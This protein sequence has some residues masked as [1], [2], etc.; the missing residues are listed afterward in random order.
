MQTT[1]LLGR[2]SRPGALD[3]MADKLLYLRIH[4]LV[5]GK[6]HQG[7]K[8]TAIK[9]YRDS[10][11]KKH[12]KQSIAVFSVRPDGECV[13]RR[14]D[15]ERVPLPWPKPG[16][17][18]P[19]DGFTQLI[20]LL[21]K[22]E[23]NV[24]TGDVE[25]NTIDD[26]DY[27]YKWQKIPDDE[28]LPGFGESDSEEQYDTQTLRDLEADVNTPSSN[29]KPKVKPPL[30]AEEAREAM[31]ECMAVMIKKWKDKRLPLLKT[32]A[33][34]LWRI[35]K[36][37][38]CRK[39]EIAKHEK[40]LDEVATRLQNM[41]EEFNRNTWW[42]LAEIKTTCL[43]MQLSL[44]EREEATWLRELMRRKN[45]PKRPEE[46]QHARKEKAVVEETER[47]EESE[48]DDG[49]DDDDETIGSESSEEFSSEDEGL[50]G[51]IVSDD[52]RDVVNGVEVEIEGEDEVEEEL[53][54]QHEEAN[55]LDSEESDSNSSEPIIARRR[56]PRNGKRVAQVVPLSDEEEEYFHDAPE[57]VNSDDMDDGPVRRSGNNKGKQGVV[58]SSDVEM[59]DVE[60]RVSP[61]TVVKAEPSNQFPKATPRKTS[62]R[63]IPVIDLTMDESPDSKKSR[64]SKN[65]VSEDSNSTFV[66]Q[67]TK[68]TRDSPNGGSGP[69][70]LISLSGSE[71]GVNAEF[72]NA[73]EL[74]EKHWG[75][76][77]DEMKG[78]IKFRFE[79]MRPLG[80]VGDL[81]YMVKSIMKQLHL[82]KSKSIPGLDD[83][84]DKIY[85]DLSKLYICWTLRKV[86]DFFRPLDSNTLEF[87]GIDHRFKAFCDALG[88][89]V[90]EF[91]EEEGTV[92]AQELARIKRKGRRQSGRQEAYAEELDES[93]DFMPT[94][95]GSQKRKRRLVQ[96]D[97]TAREKRDRALKRHRNLF[98]RIR[99]QLMNE[100]A[101]NGEIAINVGHYARHKDINFNPQLR[102]A[103]KQHQVN[104]VRFI[105]GQLVAQ[106]EGEGAGAL[107]AHTMGLGKTFQVI[108]FLYTLATAAGS[109]DPAVY[110][111]IPKELRKSR[112]LILSPP[113]LVDNWEDEFHKWIPSIENTTEMDLSNL[114]KIRRADSTKEFEFR[115]EN[116]KLWY[117]EGGVLLI[118]YATFRNFIENPLRKVKINGEVEVRP[119][120]PEKQYQE[121]KRMLH[122]GPNIIVAD[123][124][125]TLKNDSNKITR[126]AKGFKSKARIAI[127][128]SPLMNNLMEYY[129]MID[130]IDPG[131]LGSK[132]EFRSKYEIPIS[133]GVYADSDM[134]SRRYSLKMLRV[135]AKNLEPKVHRA[136]IQDIVE[137]KDVLPGKTEFMVCVP[138]TPLQKEMYLEYI[139]DPTTTG[140]AEQSLTP[141]YLLG[142]V[143]MLKL[144]ASH[145]QCFVAR[146]EN[147]EAEAQA[148]TQKFRALYNLPAAKDPIGNDNDASDI[149]A[150]E[151]PY[152]SVEPLSEEL[153][154][155]VQR[156]YPWA[157]EIFNAAGNGEAM[158]HSVKIMALKLIIE[159]SI[160]AGDQVLVFSHYIDTLNV[161]ERF[162]KEWGVEYRRLDGKTK[163]ST[164][165][166]STKEFNSGGGQ[167]YLVATEA[168]GLG[169][170]LPGA[171]RVVIFDFGWTPMSEEQAIGRSYRIGQMKHV[172][173]YR[174]YLGGT[175]EEII[176][177]KVLYKNQLQSRVVDQKDPVRKSTKIL[178]E[179]LKPPTEPPQEDLTPYMGKD[180]QVLDKIIERVD[181][182]RSIL[183]TETFESDPDDILT[184]DE[185]R[186]AELIYEE[187]MGRRR[188]KLDDYARKS[189]AKYRRKTEGWVGGVPSAAASFSAV[190]GPAG[191]SAGALPVL[192]ARTSGPP[193]ASSKAP[194]GAPIPPPGPART[195][196]PMGFPALPSAPIPAPPVISA[197]PPASFSLP[198]A[199]PATPSTLP[200]VAPIPAPPGIP[201]A[202]TPASPAL[203]TARPG[204]PRQPPTATAALPRTLPASPVPHAASPKPRVSPGSQITSGAS[205]RPPSVARASAGS[206]ALGSNRTASPTPLRT[207]LTSVAQADAPIG[208]LV[209]TTPNPPRESSKAPTTPAV[210]TTE[211]SGTLPVSTP[212]QG[213]R[214]G[215]PRGLRTSPRS[216]TP[217]QLQNGELNMGLEMDGTNDEVDRHLDLLNIA[218]SEVKNKFGLKN[219]NLPSVFG[220]GK[221]DE[222][223]K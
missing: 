140:G 127:T 71:A 182:I 41:V 136:G 209:R 129:A 87:L 70:K 179:Y 34:R 99:K 65:T 35:A 81:F 212:S 131:Y 32:R 86:P 180:L 26:W 30:S 14:E 51:F 206:N 138:L 28:V 45:G 96:E 181:F 126:A 64:R 89:I 105:W 60:G 52:T 85:R 91:Q 125:H 55:I 24:F 73:N 75:L 80:R 93:D 114:G 39:R 135:L 173:V 48:L 119:K 133:Q 130:W 213:L 195:T 8:I 42:S 222:G 97:V 59:Y 160:E 153:L 158:E 151:E 134:S 2:L 111:Q 216:G 137:K 9:P 120:F 118:S 3:C 168:G 7:R 191:N 141:K 112:T 202:A 67:A 115:I 21:D 205:P 107:L 72:E 167:V 192:P 110:N 194:W 200:W 38:R 84:N 128:G 145:P 183:F 171:N 184:L 217:T 176:Y 207:T 53:A 198:R 58:S 40:R 190:M 109:P 103:L 157:L 95:Q 218:R 152:H 62:S 78:N 13:V 61:S 36:K 104:G 116:I 47:E 124:A 102:C 142:V 5:T 25:D 33:W 154:K 90:S 132:E 101:N 161:L 63:T 170:N 46:V 113:G 122:E 56:N 143:F 165:Q 82:K 37:A 214:A 100:S 177:N 66:K 169:L 19:G 29:T 146:I 92:E 74:L 15:V 139:V 221:L 215:T 4:L 22:P 49:E 188:G 6:T 204:L 150:D 23:K 201:R 174:F 148:K 17:I 203:P 1:V 186:E 12:Q 208:S 147:R 106:P 162:M 83:M 43:A 178:K 50:N 10:L 123:E 44:W 77:S 31:Y 210:A 156:P 69:A 196:L 54:R 175:F 27:L 172:F 223:R 18:R 155:D 108:A 79:M 219:L 163:M 16:K 164:R 211:S 76:L 98:V 20:R 220:K 11:L 68:A 166:A 144:I 121:I 149:E 88:K 197:P 185:E 94:T 57:E 199:P 187:E 193:E 189:D 117:E 159:L